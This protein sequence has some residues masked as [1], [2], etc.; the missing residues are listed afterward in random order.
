MIKPPREGSSV[1]VHIIRDR[2]EIPA[3]IEDAKK[4]DQI[5]L[6]EPFVSG[7]ELTVGVLGRRALPIVYIQPKSGF[8]DMTNKYP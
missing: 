8:Y 7:K 6:V 2:S 1:G 5:V 4:Y 3:A